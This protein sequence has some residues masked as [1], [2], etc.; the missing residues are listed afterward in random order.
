MIDAIFLEIFGD[1]GG[2]FAGRLKDQAARHARPC[3]PMGQDIDHRQHERSC[4]SGAGLRNANDVA[5]HQ[6]RG[7]G[8]RL[9]RS[10]R[11]VTRRSNRVQKFIGKAEIGKRHKVPI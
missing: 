7:D 1:L 8:L 2:Q 9:D 10:R 4:F 11:V 5:H 3:P 6:D